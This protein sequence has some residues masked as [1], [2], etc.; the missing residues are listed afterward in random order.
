MYWIILFSDRVSLQTQSSLIGW[1]DWPANPGIPFSLLLL[2]SGTTTM[3]GDTGVWAIQPQIRV[4][5]WLTLYRWAPHCI[6]QLF[7]V[8]SQD[9]VISNIIIQCK[10]K[11]QKPKQKLECK[12][13][14]VKGFKFGHEPIASRVLCQGVLKE[15]VITTF[16]LWRIIRR[17]VQELWC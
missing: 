7:L 5:A 1:S 15:E 11:T 3:S 2:S 13:E 6:D 14:I 17:G 8:K 10:K 9:H 4:I 12:K 16:V